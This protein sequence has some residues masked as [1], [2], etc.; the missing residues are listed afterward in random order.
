MNTFLFYLLELTLVSGVFCFAFYFIRK[1]STPFFKRYF[2]LASI[3]FSI[4]FPFITIDTPTSP[5]L[6]IEEVVIA[7]SRSLPV[8]GNDVAIQDLSYVER[9]ELK[10][11]YFQTVPKQESFNLMNMIA[12]GYG[13]VAL[14]LLMRILVGFAQIFRLRKAASNKTSELGNYYLIEESKFRGASFFNWVFIGSGVEE[15]KETILQ[16]ELIHVK[17]KHSIDILLSHLF[18]ALFWINPFSWIVR[19]EIR[20]NTE[21]ETDFILTQRQDR[22]GYMDMLLNLYQGSKGSVVLNHFSA[23]HLKIR[24][25]EM[26]EPVK[27]R[28]WVSGLFVITV[29]GC[30]YLVSC[31]SISSEANGISESRMNEVKSITT[32]FYSH[33]ND[34]QQKTGKIVSIATF[35]PNGTLDE[36]VTQTTY[37]YDNEYEVK[38]EFWDEPQKLQ[39]P[40]IMDGLSLD[41]AENNFLYGNNWPAAFAQ[42]SKRKAAEN[43]EDFKW[44]STVEID[45]EVQPTEIKL[46]RLPKNRP[47][48]VKLEF[49]GIIE[50]FEYDEDK[51]VNHSRRYASPGMNEAMLKAIDA[52]IEK[53]K[54]EEERNRFK[55]EREISRKRISANTNEVEFRYEG[56]NLQ[57]I[58]I[59]GRKE[60]KFYYENELLTKSEFYVDGKLFNTRFH[61]YENGLKDRTE[62]F[63]MLNEPEYTI[64]Y[65]YEYW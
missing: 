11:G 48:E 41:A 23:Q 13:A 46:G 4:A 32:H 56:D 55:E 52:K 39:L 15:N 29:L 28:K 53:A 44:F 9:N 45:N 2:L 54:T 1:R 26:I 40:Y 49:S 6:Q 37:P 10:Q 57:S 24:I 21:L 30:F 14:F 19:R 43:N 3:L 33:Q 35:L 47:P 42:Y 12:I 58:L 22:S 60:H 7:S 5:P 63:N 34:T 62:I 38:R 18:T 20:I 27:Q 36:F 51:V 59:K 64:K 31:E 25:Q 16:H 8:Q 17:R 61:Y 65:S 50:L